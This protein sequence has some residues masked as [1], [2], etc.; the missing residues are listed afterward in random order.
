M[1]TKQYDSIDMRGNA[2]TD[3]ADPSSDQDA[4]TK[5]W[6]EANTL[7]TI[8]DGTTTFS[9]V[10]ELDAPPH[11]LS[12]SGSTAVIDWD[13]LHTISTSGSAATLSLVDGDTIDITLT[14]DCTFTLSGAV[15]GRSQFLT[16]VTRQD[17]TGGRDITWP[18]A[19]SWL[20][21][22][23]P[24]PDTT[25]DAVNVYVLWTFDGGTHWGGVLVGSGG[26]SALGD[27]SDVVLTSPAQ[28]D[29]LQFDGTDWVN[30]T[31]HY[32][33]HVAYDG[34]VVLNGNGDPVMVLVA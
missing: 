18:A 7:Q 34:T 11:S 22:T 15:T 32:E 1:T 28:F 33:P 14:A 9:P 27:L 8:E 25:A 30:S 19:V 4:A 31:L 24:A 17:G 13:R 6:V 5:A 10:T 23:A 21:G 26:V 16:I 3:L 2:I 12:G 29:W 20:G